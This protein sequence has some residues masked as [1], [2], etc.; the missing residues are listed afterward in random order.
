MGEAEA[1]GGAPHIM[2]S[3]LEPM[4]CQWNPMQSQRWTAELLSLDKVTSKQSRP[5]PNPWRYRDGSLRPDRPPYYTGVETPVSP[6][7]EPAVRH[8]EVG[9]LVPNA[10]LL[11]PALPSPRSVPRPGGLV[12]DVPA[13]HDHLP[14]PVNRRSYEQGKVPRTWAADRTNYD[15]SVQNTP[16]SAR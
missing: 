11:R 10:G 6:R 8:N 5:A 2:S 7:F 14:W 9:T 4:R 1:T 16:R 3:G 12:D 15:K 13:E